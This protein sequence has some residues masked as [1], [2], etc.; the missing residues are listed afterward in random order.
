ML[1]SHLKLS[2]FVFVSVIQVGFEDACTK[3]TWLSKNELARKMWHGA[4]ISKTEKN[5]Y[6]KIEKNVVPET[7]IFVVD[8][9]INRL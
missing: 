1:F 5:S 4:V 2:L 6:L 8:I 3:K 7:C 9:C